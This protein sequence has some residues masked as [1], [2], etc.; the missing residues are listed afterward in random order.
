MIIIMMIIIIIIIIIL[1]MLL[2]LLRFKVKVVKDNY[3]LAKY[4]NTFFVY[5]YVFESN[6]LAH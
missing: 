2:R 5:I 3:P 6:C 4:P 1:I